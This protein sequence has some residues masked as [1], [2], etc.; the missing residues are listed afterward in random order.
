[1]ANSMDN[2]PHGKILDLID[3]IW[4][5]LTGLTALLV[6][7]VK[8]WWSDR[9]AAKREVADLRKVVLWLKEHA[10]TGD[11]LHECRK[12]VREVDDKNLDMIFKE[13]RAHTERNAAQH[14]EIKKEVRS[15]I[16]GVMN[17]I[18]DLYSKDK[19]L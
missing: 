10:V 6:G 19:K 17:K 1:M 2:V 11:E 14:E 15:E 16:R 3:H 13:M 12:E 4:P 7:G 18:I 9:N 8:L 5:Y